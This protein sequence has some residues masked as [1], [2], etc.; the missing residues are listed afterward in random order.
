[1]AERRGDAHQAGGG[2]THVEHTERI[3]VARLH[4]KAP[5]VTALRRVP[6]GALD[7]VRV[8]ERGDEWRIEAIEFGPIPTQVL[9]ERKS[10]NH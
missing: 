3:C 2:R 4:A 10:K 8:L 5:H 9:I 6:R 1:M 7:L